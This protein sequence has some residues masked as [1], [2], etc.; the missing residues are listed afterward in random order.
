MTL[1]HP[2]RRALQEVV[3]RSSSEE[4][5]LHVEQVVQ[6]AR[7]Q[8]QRARTQ[9]SKLQSGLSVDQA[10]SALVSQKAY[11]VLGYPLLPPAPSKPFDT[12]ASSRFLTTSSFN[13]SPSLLFP[14][15]FL[16]FPVASPVS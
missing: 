15:P 13:H 3:A 7:E 6:N 2:R 1:S 14:G 4:D 12:H 16:I 5:R 11:Q 9:V 10:L 8:L